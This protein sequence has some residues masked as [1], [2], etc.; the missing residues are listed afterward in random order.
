MSYFK[1]I[2]NEY[3]LQWANI[4]LGQAVV[5]NLSGLNDI[6]LKG[7]KGFGVGWIITLHTTRFFGDIFV[8]TWLFGRI[9]CVCVIITTKT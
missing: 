2:C 9:V 8:V 4:R 1:H 6:E 5:I 3:Y 7:F